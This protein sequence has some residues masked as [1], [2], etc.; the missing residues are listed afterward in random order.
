MRVSVYAVINAL[1]IVLA[2][3][4]A[5]FGG[6]GLW[7]FVTIA[8]IFSGRGLISGTKKCNAPAAASVLL[9]PIILKDLGDVELGL[10]WA[11]FIIIVVLPFK[12]NAVSGN[13][14]ITTEQELLPATLW[15]IWGENSHT[16]LY[17]NGEAAGMS[18]ALDWGA[19]PQP[20][21]PACTAQRLMRPANRLSGHGAG[22][23]GRGGYKR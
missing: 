13:D 16:R 17:E 21:L 5:G 9:V 8:A 20:R 10:M 1:G 19:Y 6:G 11:A 7:V 2:I 14:G 4:G 12:T 23:S 18:A 15:T 22:Q 3:V